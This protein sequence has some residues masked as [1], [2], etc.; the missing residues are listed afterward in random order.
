MKWKGGEVEN[1]VNCG[2]VRFVEISD[3]DFFDI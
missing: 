2:L 1:K 3:Y